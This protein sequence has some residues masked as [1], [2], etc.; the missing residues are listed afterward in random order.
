MQLLVT[1]EKGYQMI[2]FFTM[3]KKKILWVTIQKGNK[4]TNF[5]TMEEKRVTGSDNRIRLSW[6]QLF[7]NGEEKATGS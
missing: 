2:N 1:I 6:D 4:N 3:E 7:Y 5:I